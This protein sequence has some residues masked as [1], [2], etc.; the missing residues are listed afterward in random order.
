MP[1]SITQA[2][3]NKMPA[4]LLIA[5]PCSG[6][7]ETLMGW[8]ESFKIF[9]VNRQSGDRT[10]DPESLELLPF[11]PTGSASRTTL[12]QD[13][14][15]EIDGC[16]LR[17][18]DVPGEIANKE[19]RQ[20]GNYRTRLE[21][22]QP[23]LRG[24]IV[25]V[26][27]PTNEPQGKI[28]DAS[29][30]K[31]DVGGAD[32]LDTDSTKRQLQCSM[33]FTES[34]I[35]RQGT[36]SMQCT[37]V[38][39]IGFADLTDFAG[40]I[41]EI[42]TYRKE[43]Q[44]IWP[45]AESLSLKSVADVAAR[46]RHYDRVSRTAER[47][48]PWL[49]GALIRYRALNPWFVLQSNKNRVNLGKYLRVMSLIYMADQEFGR[50]LI[51]K[52]DEAKRELLRKQKEDRR[53]RAR[54]IAESLVMSVTVF[55]VCAW[56]GYT[57][58]PEFL[59]DSLA[60]SSC[61]ET[62]LANPAR[63]C[64][65]LDI[66]TRTGG[67]GTLEQDLHILEPYRGSC[68]AFAE[69]HVQKDQTML[70][71]LV[72]VELARALVNPGESCLPKMRDAM[73]ELPLPRDPNAARMF[74]ARTQGETAL[75]LWLADAIDG[76]PPKSAHALLSDISD[77]DRGRFPR[78]VEMLGKVGGVS[79]CYQAWVR[80]RQN[81]S[82]SVV[83]SSCNMPNVVLPAKAA[84]RL[85]ADAVGWKVKVRTATES[86]NKES[87]VGSLEAGLSSFPCN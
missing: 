72:R 9:S 55:A 53:R 51:E 34:L 41:D 21:E 24:V 36:S 30:F 57:R 11:Q 74:P 10:S 47:Q 6:K 42:D 66:L 75:T 26:V 60:V 27:P 76:K 7:T 87:C 1:D 43:C 38:V 16:R 64:A 19:N 37:V 58:F 63:R 3:L 33:D 40:K 39:Q 78:F 13:Y 67:G 50:A 44:T 23:N 85:L 79:D 77:E 48:F 46:L 49:D 54:R 52:N 15:V 4:I 84:E 61:R 14:V 20:A 29:Q 86:D 31:S 83:A 18:I 56:L 81:G 22:F 69:Q 8:A 70:P 62:D 68:S 80:A 59:P 32:P 82:W 71:P 17:V 45:V 65:C 25:F 73:S 28:L 2:D 35:S 5:L 12:V